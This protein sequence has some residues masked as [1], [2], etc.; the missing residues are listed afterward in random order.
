MTKVLRKYRNWFLALF[1]SFLMVSFLMTGSSSMFQPDPLKQVEGTLLGEKVRVNEGMHAAAELEAVKMLAGNLVENNLGIQDGL[2]WLMLTREAERGGLVG[3]ELDGRESLTDIARS[4]VPVVIRDRTIQDLRQN[5]PQMF[6]MVRRNPDFLNFF[7]Q[8][9]MQRLTQSDVDGIAS[10]LNQQMIEGIPRAAGN[11]RLQIPEVEIALAK[12]R[13]IIRLQNTYLSAGRLSDRRYINAS[14]GA[15]D[16]VIV[17]ALAIPGATLA[18]PTFAPTAEQILAQFDQFKNFV[19]GDGETGIGYQQP[20]SVRLEWI[21][22]NRESIANAITLDL[23]DVSKHWQQNR[24]RF[25]GTIEAEKVNVEADL[26]SARVTEALAEVDRAWKARVRADLRRI[27]VIQG[28]KQLSADWASTRAPMATYAQAMSETVLAA[29][30]FNIPTP[31]VQSRTT[32]WLRVRDAGNL[33]DI[34]RAQFN[35]GSRDFPL[36]ALLAQAYELSDD[37]TLGLQVGVPFESSLIDDAGNRYYLLVTS[38]RKA[39]APDSVDEVRDQVV[40]HLREQ[41][42]YELATQRIAEFQA[43][44]ASEGL[45]VLAAE[46]NASITDPSA[47]RVSVSRNLEFSRKTAD[48]R[49]GLANSDQVRDEVIRIGGILGALT[50]ASTENQ[51]LRTGGAGSKPDRTV[52]IFQINGM[53]PFTQEDLRSRPA[54]ASMRLTVAELSEIADDSNASDA[55]SFDA[56]KERLNWKPVGP[57]KKTSESNDP[58]KPSTTPTPTTTSTPT[59]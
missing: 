28:V 22:V 25:P 19:P 23:K 16:V 49:L 29:L 8:Q 57:A 17:D 32:S 56:V 41:H 26:K 34:G 3:N 36:S 12:L 43:K 51:A 9:N 33:P 30:K 40:R 48:S 39:S 6:E 27:Q 20:I 1:G 45:D 47:S 53:R 52:V 21:E 35:A 13:G 58:S 4:M 54:T 42:G 18:E 2:H 11:A 24:A 15:S 7:V 46:I 38:A 14:R 50:Q 37:S 55:F 10:Q 59:N 44:A 31:T 5:Q